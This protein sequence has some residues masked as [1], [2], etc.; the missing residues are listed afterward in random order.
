MRGEYVSSMGLGALAV[1]HRHDKDSDGGGYDRAARKGPVLPIVPLRR[2][3]GVGR[4][5]AGGLGLEGGS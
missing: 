1:I 3:A 4:A 5:A 2:A